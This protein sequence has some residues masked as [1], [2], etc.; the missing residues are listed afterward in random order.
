MKLDHVK[1]HL[2]ETMDDVRDFNAWFTA[3]P[4]QYGKM[5]FD[6]E[7]TG[8][9]P[10][11]DRVRLAQLGDGNE[12]WAFAWEGPLASSF[13]FTDAVTRFQGTLLAHN[14]PFDYA[15]FTKAGV[16]LDRSRIQCTRIKSHIQEPH[17]PT[18]LKPQSRRHVDARSSQLQ[19]ELDE[20]LARLGW[21]GIPVTFGP[22]WYY[23]AL[24]PVLTYHLDEHHN[25]GLPPVAFDV[26]NAVQFVLETMMRRGACVDVDY[27]RHNQDLFKKFCADT[28]QW[29][30]NEFG[31]SPGSD[32]SVLRVLEGAGYEFS[33][34]TKSGALSLD[35]EVLEPIDHPLAVAVLKYRKITKLSST[36]LD[37]YITKNLQ[38]RIHC[39]INSVGARTGRMSVSE[40]NL[41]N[42]PKIQE[43]NKFANVVRNCIVARPD[44]TLVLCDFAQIETR[45][46]AHLSQDPGLLAAFHSPEDFFVVL[47]RQIFQDESLSKKDPRRNI[48]KTLVYAKIYGAG[49]AKMA[50]TLGLTYNAMVEIDD[51][52]NTTYP[53]IKLFQQQVYTEAARNK[54][55]TG[56]SFVICPL[57]GRRHI[58][59][60]GKEY[61]LVNY[62]IQGMAAFLFKIKLLELSNTE[63]SDWMI[64]PVHDEIILDVPDDR[65]DD[66]A[67]ILIQIMNDD[68]TLSVPVQAEVSTGKRWAE[69]KDYDVSRVA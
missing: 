12:G 11:L 57:S 37:H 7:T 43:G 44:H 35:K 60:P 30:R 23:G 9:S 48:I 50:K 20:A 1:L 8:L 10:E 67:R 42:L 27:A 52:L 64:L 28:A 3:G 69:K 46:L 24:D 34:L 65:V 68:K 25:Q 53:G 56:V 32:Q 54:R 31:V 29:C 63:A 6:C 61:A 36:Y 22:Y 51:A 21:D 2:I 55:E 17:L 47:A 58:A 13:V 15:M 40:P 66:C 38:G 59:D 5:A 39:S 33:K 18:A 49:L 41:Q 26:E 19:Q 14:A 62:L 4:L 16:K 45:L